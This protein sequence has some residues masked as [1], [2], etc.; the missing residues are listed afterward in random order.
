MELS[1]WTYMDKKMQLSRVCNHVTNFEAFNMTIGVAK[2]KTLAEYRPISLTNFTGKLVSRI[3]SNRL[4][5]ILPKLVE[6]NQSGFVRGRSIHEAIALVQEMAHSIDKKCFGGNVIM[7]IDMSK[8]YDRLEWRFLLTT[9]RKMGFCEIFTDIIYRNI[10][11]INYTFSANGQCHGMFQSSRGV[12][13]GDPLSPLLFVI[14]QQAL[15]HNLNKLMDQG[16][17]VP[18]NMGQKIDPISHLLY[19]D[20]MIIFINGKTDNIERLKALLNRYE[21]SSG[22]LINYDKTEVYLSKHISDTRKQKIKDKLGCRIA[23]FPF[24]YLGAPICKGRIK[25]I[26]FDQLIQ[27]VI[28]K[29]EG[30]KSKFLSFAGKL[31]LLKSVLNSLPIHIMSAVAVNKGVVKHLEKLFKTFLW[32]QKGQSRTHWEQMEELNNIILDEGAEDTLIY[33]NHPSGKFTTRNYIEGQKTHGIQVPWADKVWNKNLPSK[34][35]TFLWKLMHK[36]IPVDDRIK[37]KGVMGPFRCNC[38]KLGDMETLNHLFLNSEIDD[39]GMDMQH[40]HIETDSL[41]VYKIVRGE[42]IHSELSYLTRRN[43]E[44]LKNLQHILREQN[45]AA[46]AIAKIGG[47]VPHDVQAKRQT[48]QRGN[49]VSLPCVVCDQRLVYEPPLAASAASIVSCFIRPKL[50]VY[51]DDLHG[52]EGSIDGHV[53]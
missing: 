22:Q 5:R 36:A 50:Q 28:T 23:E 31:T 13:Q 20:D 25:N 6:E 11:G 43:K 18:F 2:P 33:T 15:T 34:V 52:I 24:T 37:D 19:A 51:E 46:D 53:A 30:W 7:K 9:M 35:V 29:L 45:M 39:E 44:Q 38:C 42:D 21:K 1:S 16:A 32:S 12:R 17:L 40:I 3:I 49:T 26:Y 27:K 41:K 47:A 4:N 14:A 10:S 48:P 8:A